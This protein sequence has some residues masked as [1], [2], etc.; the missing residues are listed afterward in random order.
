MVFT[1]V[2]MII[3]YL[4][5]K[6]ATQLLLV[7]WLVGC[8]VGHNFLKRKVTLLLSDHFFWLNISHIGIANLISR[9]TGVQPAPPPLVINLISRYTGVQPAPPPGNIHT[10]PSEDVWAQMDLQ[11]NYM[12]DDFT[13]FNRLKNKD[14][15]QDILSKYSLDW[16]N[17]SN[18][19]KHTHTHTNTHTHC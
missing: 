7:G 12:Y 9:Y 6:H 15:Y 18:S 13:M 19:H 17:S 2:L 8:S 14:L 3:W 10:S 5:L 11:V 1:Y 4:S 16:P